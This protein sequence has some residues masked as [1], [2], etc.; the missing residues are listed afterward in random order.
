MRCAGHALRAVSAKWMPRWPALWAERAGLARA[1]AAR[2]VGGG[3]S[4]DP[5]EVRGTRR[6]DREAPRRAATRLRATA[7]TG[8]RQIVER[9]GEAEAAAS[10]PSPA[11]PI[12]THAPEPAPVA[13][14]ASRLDGQHGG[15]GGARSPTLGSVVG[16]IIGAGGSVPVDRVLAPMAKG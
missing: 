7:T 12:G 13:R 11:P 6:A 16:Q 5:A 14:C 10:R 3:E 8:A 9:A 4:T 2:E 1:R 15:D